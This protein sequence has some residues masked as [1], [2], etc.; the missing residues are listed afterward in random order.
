MYLNRTDSELI[1]ANALA[2]A[3]EISHQPDAWRNTLRG[4]QPQQEAIR[5]FIQ[6]FFAYPNGRIVLT[7]AGTSAFAGRALAPYLSS[8]LKRRIEAVATTDIVTAPLEYFAENCP[9]L[10]ISFARSGN[11]PESVAA[12]DLANQVLEHCYH[13]VITCNETGN[14]YTRSKNDSNS[15]ALLMPPETNDVSF[16]MTSSLTSMM[17]ACLHAL[18]PE[19][20]TADRFEAVAQACQT[21]LAERVA[22]I[23]ALASLQVQ[24][25]IYLG[26]GSLQGIAQESALKLLEL[27]AGKLSVTFDSPVGFRHGPKSVVDESSIIFI[28]ISNDPYTR[29]Y[30]IDLLKELRAENKALRIVALTTHID[31]VIADGDYLPI[32]SFQGMNDVTLSFP[33]L[34]F[35]QVYA[36]MC[37]LNLGVGPDNPCPSGSVNRVVQGVKIYPF[38]Y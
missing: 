12:I 36:F 28:Y 23:N 17:V 9:T 29:Q 1:E 7:G 25:V 21:M 3:I 26:S 38:D 2:T 32:P 30:D 19:E 16:A 20:F 31:S 10:V 27:T 34:I 33:L 6:R 8:Q 37:S 4:L 5:D 13:L 11:S 18:L 24:K 15:L 14:L 22:D 35:A